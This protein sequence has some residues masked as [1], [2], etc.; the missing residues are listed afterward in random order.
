MNQENSTTPLPEWPLEKIHERL[1]LASTIA[2]S[3]LSAVQLTSTARLI[4]IPQ[5]SHKY[6][7]ANWH[8]FI[9]TRVNKDTQYEPTACHT[10]K[11][12]R[13]CLRQRLSASGMFCLGPDQFPHR[14]V[15]RNHFIQRDHMGSREIE[16]THF[17]PFPVHS[18]KGI[19]IG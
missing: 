9:I 3:L 12:H 6:A 16:N 5:I 18:K 11:N 19:R 13:S 8:Y 15:Y 10:H 4:L 7:S 2:T 14:K 1:I 17:Q